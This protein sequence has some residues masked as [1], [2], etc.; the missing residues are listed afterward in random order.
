M[1][2]AG[3]TQGGFYGHFDSKDDLIG[4]ALGHAIDT[5][6]GATFGLRAFINEYLSPQYRD[7]SA[8]GCP[9]AGLAGT[10]EARSALTDGVRA[11][12]D[13]MFEKLTGMD[14]A[15]RRRQAIASYAAMVGAMIVPRAITDPALSDEILKETR[16]WIDAGLDRT[17]AMASQTAW[18]LD[19][20]RM[21]V[22]QSP[23]H[24]AEK[25]T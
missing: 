8:G 2:A 22:H 16:A 3:L 17:A 13:W 12:I 1:K 10:L 7:N 4:L 20:N 24:L 6:K 9:V 19:L 14:E 23:D 21:A 15:D 5:R 18:R 25:P 11:Q